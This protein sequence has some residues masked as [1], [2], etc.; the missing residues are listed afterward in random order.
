MNIREHLSAIIFTHCSLLWHSK[1][2]NLFTSVIASRYFKTVY[3]EVTVKLYT[4]SLR[5]VISLSFHFQRLR[6][7]VAFWSLIVLVKD[8]YPSLT[9]PP[10]L[11][12]R[13]RGGNQS[14]VPWATDLVYS[15]AVKPTTDRRNHKFVYLYALVTTKY[16]LLVT[17]PII[18]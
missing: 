3:N 16:H 11:T 8:T 15:R 9:Q 7:T 18:N 6:P 17:F 5:N 13:L 12:S 14:L 4:Y 2:M 1:T 10:Y